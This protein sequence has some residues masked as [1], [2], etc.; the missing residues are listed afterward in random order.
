MKLS[1]GVQIKDGKLILNNEAYFKTR[2][3]NIENGKYMIRIEPTKEREKRT[4]HQN[5]A[6]HLWFEMVAQELNAAGYTVQLVLKEKV[7]IDWDKDKVKELLWRTAQQA[8]TGKKS[9]TELWKTEDIDKIY[10]HLN[11]HLGE[12]FGVHIPF[13]THEI[14]YHDKVHEK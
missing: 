13:P 3:K 6:L 10:E 8:I 12:K 9:T 5:R 4:Y 2:L 11:R 14:G 1:F 7:D